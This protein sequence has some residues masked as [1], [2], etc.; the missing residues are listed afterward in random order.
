[1]YPELDNNYVLY[2]VGEKDWNNENN[3][4]EPFL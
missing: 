1:M 3:V 2:S 4:Y